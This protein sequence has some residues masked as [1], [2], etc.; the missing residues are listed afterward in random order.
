MARADYCGDGA[1]HTLDGT[2]IDIYDGLGIQKKTL[3]DD[4]MMF[5]ASWSVNG[6]TCVS[7][8]RGATIS[9]RKDQKRSPMMPTAMIEH[10]MMGQIGHP[11]A[12]M[13]ANK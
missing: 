12:S 6:A 10:R 7:K 1:S 9:W 2:W 4:G 5:E 13:M 3:D 8:P 11:A